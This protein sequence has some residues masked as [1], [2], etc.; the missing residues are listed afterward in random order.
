MTLCVNNRK[1]VLANP[2]TFAAIA[3]A[4]RTLRKWHVLA[5]VAMPDHLHAIVNPMIDREISLGDF[6]TGFKRI[7]RQ[8]LGGQP[9]QWQRGCFDRLARSDENVWAKWQYLRENPVR[10]GLTD[11]WQAWAFFYIAPECEL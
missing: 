5:A 2:R 6:S 4:F 8:R 10:S 9:W 11:A 1:Q 7:V 3:Y